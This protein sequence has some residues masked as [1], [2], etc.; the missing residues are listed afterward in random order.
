MKNKS[1]F[2]MKREYLK[3]VKTSSFWLATLFFPIFIVV[4]SLVSGYSG[5][6]FEERMREIAESANRIA[7]YDETGIISDD[8]IVEPF[9]RVDDFEAALSEVKGEEIDALFV[10]QENFVEEGIEVY[11]QDEGIFSMGIFNDLAINIIRQSIIVSLDDPQQ[12]SAMVADLRVDETLYAEGVETDFAIEQFIIPG[13]S[14]ALYFILV[15]FSTSYLLLSVSEE[16]ENRVI[17]T[18][19]SVVKPRELILGKLSGQVGVV[20]TQLFTL[21]LLAFVGLRLTEA[22]IPIEIDWASVEINLGQI[23]LAIFYTATGFLILA[24]MMIAVA[25]A[26]PSYKEA[27]SFSSVFVIASIAPIWF[28]MSIVAEPSG[29]LATILSFT[30]FTAPF[31]LLFRNALG[32]LSTLQAT[33][34]LFVLLSYVLISFYFAFKMFELGSLQFGKNVNLK[35]IFKR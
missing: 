14:V 24:N 22:S 20:L 29:T 6:A 17:E 5:A 10:Y 23:L 35:K 34:S 11:A 28:I 2:I 15:A 9:E 19:L 21:L 13:I 3:V 31:I 26:V 4:I 1:W 30:P 12:I 25:S 27:Q 18:V 16:K 8:L 33:L 32:E 7:I